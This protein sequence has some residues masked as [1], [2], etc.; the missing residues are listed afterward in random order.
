MFERGAAPAPGR[1]PV[2][3]RIPLLRSGEEWT[4][5]R[6][7]VAARGRLAVGQFDVWG[8]RKGRAPRAAAVGARERLPVERGDVRG[9]G[10]WRASQGAAVGARERLPV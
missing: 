4:A 9:C 6:V 8:G 2:G 3:S 10:E 5:R 7:K 1:S